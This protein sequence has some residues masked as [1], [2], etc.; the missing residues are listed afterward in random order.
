MLSRDN[1]GL[2]STETM[3]VSP[4]GHRVY[5]GERSS[6]DSERL[7][8]AVVTLDD[9]GKPVGQPQL[10]PDS[11][12]P[13]QPGDMAGVDHLLLD[14]ADHKL[15]LISNEF[16][17]S[18]LANAGGPVSAS[19]TIYDLDAY[20]DP[21][22]ADA[23]HPTEGPQTIAVPDLQVP[24]LSS[25]AMNPNPALKL[26]YVGGYEEPT[27]YA[28]NL[29]DLDAARAPGAAPPL[30]KEYNVGAGGQ[31]DIGVSPYS[32]G[33]PWYMYLGTTAF[34]AAKQVAPQ[35][36][37]LNL[38]QNGAPIPGTERF[39]W[40]SPSLPDS[41]P[42]FFEF[43]Y[44][45]QALYQRRNLP[46][47]ASSP[48][49]LGVEVW[50]LDQVTGNPT[51]ADGQDGGPPQI[52]SEFTGRATA[53]D[54]AN[55]RVWLAADDTFTDATNGQT[56][57][58]GT[59]PIAY[60]VNGS[61]LPVAKA[62]DVTTVTSYVQNGLLMAV[63]ADGTPVVLTQA[64]PT[65]IPGNQVHGAW[66]T[67]SI[68]STSAPP[69]TKFDLRLE[70]GGN[71]AE[72]GTL[73]VG[74]TSAQV[75]LDPYLKDVSGQ[76][77]L[78]VDVVAPDP[79]VV[80]NSLTLTLKVWPGDPNPDDAPVSMTETVQGNSVDFLVPGYRFLP[81]GQ[82]RADIQ[83]ISQHAQEY[84][85]K[86]EQ[87]GLVPSDRPQHFAISTGLFGGEGSQPLLQT[88]AQ[89]LALLGITS[90]NTSGW[91][92]L[93]P[94][95]IN[96]VLD[97]DRGDGQ[98]LIPW[99]S[100]N[101]FLKD[102]VKDSVPNLDPSLPGF[103][104]FCIETVILDDSKFWINVKKHETTALQTDNGGTPDQ[105]AMFSMEDEPAWFNGG[106][107]V[108]SDQDAPNAVVANAQTH[109]EWLQAF[110]DYLSGK[111]T[112]GDFGATSWDQVF[113][114]DASK[115]TT[116]VES[117][118]LFYWTV[119][120][121]SDQADQGLAL[122]RKELQ[123]VFP[124]TQ[125]IYAD[126][127]NFPDF[128]YTNSSIPAP[129]NEAAMG[130]PDWLEA[131]RLGVTPW[132]EPPG[133]N[134]GGD[135]FSEWL[136]E[137][138]DILR[139][140][141]MEGMLPGGSSTVPSFGGIVR[142]N[143][144]GYFPAGASYKILSLLGQ[145]AKAIDLFGFGPSFFSSDG[146]SEDLGAYGPIADA[147]RLVAHAEPVLYP[148]QPQRGKVALLLPNGSTLWDPL[149]ADGSGPLYQQEVQALDYA[150]VHEGYTV[151]F[152]DDTD[153][154]NGALATRGYSALYLTGPNL[155]AAAQ[156]KVQAWVAG[157]GTLVVTPGAAVNDEYNTPI[158]TLDEVLGLQ[159][160]QVDRTLVSGAEVP[161]H[162]LTITD[163]SAGFGSA[164][165]LV[166]YGP[167]TPL[168]AAGAT[169]EGALG[170][171]QDGNTTK[172]NIVVTGLTT[173]QLKV[174]M[175]VSGPGI[176]ANTTILHI[177]NGSAITLSNK[178]TADGTTWLT[179]DGASAGAGITLHQ[180]GHGTA[181]AYGFF[182]GWQ[183]WMSTNDPNPGAPQHPNTLPQHWGQAQVQL[184]D[185]P[186][187]LANTPKPVMV[188]HDQVQ[189]DLLQSGKGIAITLL[190]WSGQPIPSL[191]VCIPNASS[192]TTV[193]T[194]QGVPI[195]T[196]VIG[197]SLQVTLPLNDVDVLML[198]NSDATATIDG[199]K[200][201]DHFV[202]TPTSVT[203][204]GQTVLS[205]PYSKLTLNGLGG[206][207]TFTVLGTPAGSQVILN[208]GDGN[209]TFHIGGDPQLGSPETLDAVA[210]SI[211]IDGEAGTNTLT[212]DDQ[213]GMAGRTYTVSSTGVTW[214]GG[215]VS[216]TNVDTIAV[217]AGNGDDT[218][219][220]LGTPAG[221]QVTLDG[222]GGN[223]SV[224]VSPTDHNLNDLG[225][226]LT[227]DGQ[228][229]TVSLTINDQASTPAASANLT[230]TSTTVT[231]DGA[232]TL[233]YAG[234]DNLTVNSGR[235]DD[236]REV[237]VVNS[238][239][240][241]TNVTV[242]N[243]SS[244]TTVEFAVGSAS[245]TLDGIQG[246]LTFHG[247]A[248]SSDFLL[249]SDFVNASARDYT[250]TPL[251]GVKS[252]QIARSG[253]APISFD[254]LVEQILYTSNTVGA[255][256]AVLGNAVPTFLY[257]GPNAK[258]NAGDQGLL[259]GFQA[260]FEV[261][262]NA[263]QPATVRLDDSEDVTSRQATVNRSSVGNGGIDGLAKGRFEWQV[264]SGASMNVQIL[265]GTGSN[266]FTVQSAP[267]RVALSIDGG[268]GSNTLVGPDAASVWQIAGN[269][270]GALP[271][272]VTFSS[273][274]NLTGGSGNDTF[275]IGA[276]GLL[277]GTINGGGGVNALD[278][279]G[280]TGDIV[281]DLPLDMAA[282]VGSVSGIVDV[283]G[284]IGN[285][286]L[287]GDGSGNQLTGGQGR[288]ILIAG[289]SAA[290]LTGGPDDDIL[291]GGSTAYDTNL[292][293]L[294]A[295]MAEWSRK[296][297]YATRVKHILRGGGFNGSTL[298]NPSTFTA[299]AGGNTLTGAA[300]R[301]LFFGSPALD[302]NDWNP[303]LG[304]V[305]V[306]PNGV[307]AAIRIAVS[308]LGGRDLLLDGAQALSDLSSQLLTLTAG[309]HTLSDSALGTSVSFTVSDTGTVSYDS[310][311]EGVLTG[312]GTSTLTV[313][314]RTITIDTR[315]LS[316]PLLTLNNDMLV[317]NIAPFVLSGLP[318]SYTLANDA[319]T[320]NSVSFI[321][322]PDGSVNY[323]PKLN[324][325]L[326][327]RGTSTLTVLGRTIQ[328]NATA[329][330]QRNIPTFQIVGVGTFSTSQIQTVT[331]L[332]GP[333]TFVDATS[334]FAFTLTLS[335]TVD[336]VH[337]LDGQLGG[338]GTRELVIL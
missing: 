10:Y 28:Y 234:I 57:T 248:G 230:I 144:L 309:S 52:L 210:G 109:P 92:G 38:D 40:A 243:A 325:I 63:T 112:P 23:K 97:S 236:Q 103:F 283:I 311:L 162:T 147:T 164:S 304:E 14:A 200:G 90:V 142:G 247:R 25:L 278:F 328:I 196:Q 80:L 116:S 318:G 286:I 160:R 111:G 58:D 21:I 154:A 122:F 107:D 94:T 202:I 313:Q 305:F 70:A 60:S 24:V 135:A 306:G 102:L 173:S 161:D 75:G 285:D 217:L 141:A 336:Y 188:S 187:D 151:D 264:G 15:F 159:S 288:N 59:T 71:S 56:V 206:N 2:G 275:Q 294:N 48:D 20:G 216:C 293:A 37:V 235:G 81:P 26:L 279:S 303:S 289:A 169:V 301:D 296:L 155:S 307:A 125:N 73:G 214:N 261:F 95:Q 224:V 308:G 231:R 321:L 106:R 316:I 168:Q 181:I 277:S 319:G 124:A 100:F 240:K 269:N 123:S 180:Y 119:H 323:A 108:A 149:P 27:L 17:E 29:D 195:Q 175:S 34:N 300:G 130:G 115:V 259:A 274:Q 222:G 199:T 87:V 12:V 78:R 256:V 176:P 1:L 85:A 82:R 114:I 273:F 233:T 165:S 150:L 158:P 11:T 163:T 133:N 315:A 331:L 16:V 179:F 182:P 51:G 298:L 183:Y 317:S 220:V 46:P 120:F 101:D 310:A 139:S 43:Y 166:L 88:E 250:L 262:T 41:N 99:R 177:V 249:A 96:A 290:T 134:P 79:A 77:L 186:A 117:H 121:F 297:P 105:L 19:L 33:K 55:G 208:G 270:A 334:E 194:A 156:Q 225:G 295:L 223:D 9:T 91:T 84:L 255:T 257:A 22:L 62:P 207:D 237:V 320:G 64:I 61:G 31:Y 209:D 69:G 167:V 263:T 5:L 3:A 291:V 72:V 47:D 39:F 265:G 232:P 18:G 324:A 287:V 8:L 329:L 198:Q 44:T 110:R 89:A 118:R 280:Y 74:D 211:K 113:P 241:N 30:P 13:L 140:A 242:S 215:T 53:V 335:G 42:H 178:A 68:G 281:V 201:D 254:N 212:I 327:G 45:P 192:F 218:F 227:V 172:G 126:W 190:N 246:P 253:M 184:A 268:A 332:P 326:S 244:A 127:S 65:P 197:T 219:T 128:L 76:Q 50:P 32:P 171:R 67:V 276:M 213:A 136:S 131:G 6:T 272:G 260:I 238:T 54:P 137:A 266:T 35:L 36:E 267:P 251:A 4:D 205:G 191:T 271:G 143:T 284:S 252:A 338:R 129:T 152:L 282:Q 203:L 228:G 239:P 174:G 314:G 49:S 302:A 229:G 104:A 146:W 66:V 170:I 145:G 312:A 299:N 148:G 7:N 337:L 138:A 193:C 157:G 221:S 292:T 258:V 322:A 226:A 245:L 153:L 93:Q 189:A 86:A 98:P 132:L 330:S 185:A 333:V 204:N 83:M